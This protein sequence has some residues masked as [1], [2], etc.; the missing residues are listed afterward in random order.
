M[1]Y[2]R[3]RNV[4]EDLA[5][6]IPTGEYVADK[7]P[8]FD[9]GYALVFRR[10]GEPWKVT[11]AGSVQSAMKMYRAAKRLCKNFR[12]IMGAWS[13]YS[14]GIVYGATTVSYPH[15]RT[16]WYAAGVIRDDKEG[17]VVTDE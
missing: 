12:G 2:L 13:E 5:Y 9:K 14:Y 8:Y 10:N 11:Y 16:E 1:K 6:E 17:E 15:P 3:G 7:L 4:I